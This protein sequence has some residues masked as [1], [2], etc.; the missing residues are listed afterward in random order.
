MS[1]KEEPIGWFSLKGGKRIPIFEG[2]SKADAVKSALGKSDEGSELKKSEPVKRDR[3]EAVKLQQSKDADTKEHNIKSAQDTAKQLNAEDKYRDTLKAGTKTAIKDGRMTFNGKPVDKI[4]LSDA[5]EKGEQ[6]LADHSKNGELSAERLEVHRQILEDYFKGHQPYGP[7]DEKVAMY[8]GG[9][10]ASG[11]GVFSKTDT[12]KNIHNIGKYYSQDK[13]PLVI[14][15]DEIKKSLAK[16]DGKELDVSLTSYYHEESSA[17]AKQ[18]YNTA[19]QN[20]YPTFYDGTATGGG[21]YKLLDSA[22]KYGY[23]TEMNFITSDWKTVRQNSLDRLDSTGR[24]VPPE[25]VVGAHRKAYDAI[26]KLKDKVDSF[27]LW[28]N[29]GR[30]LRQVGKGGTGR[31]FKVSNND[32]WKRIQ[33]SKSEFTLDTATISQYNREA[34]E[35]EERRKVRLEAERRAKMNH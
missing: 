12:E 31:E 21:I 29:A 24:F 32:S 35:I 26:D 1:R 14:D 17:L 30:N 25:Q 4:D 5:G 9:G 22:K 11:K 18:I 33:Q 16:A 27:T 19:L 3:K 8:T 34:K 23:K 2:Q 13:N 6:S 7:N 20:N 10:G 28:D 15:P